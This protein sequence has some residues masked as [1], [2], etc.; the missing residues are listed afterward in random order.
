LKNSSGFLLQDFMEAT[1]PISFF[2]SF[3][4]LDTEVHTEVQPLTLENVQTHETLVISICEYGYVLISR[5]PTGVNEEWI[6][7]MSQ[8]D[9]WKYRKIS[10]DGN[11]N[12]YE[13][14]SC[15]SDV[16]GK[17]TSSLSDDEIRHYPPEIKAISRKRKATNK[18]MKKKGKKSRKKRKQS[19][20]KKTK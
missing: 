7:E 17:Y 11:D 12:R 13:Y 15:S 16:Y 1:Q 10:I 19:R 9:L 20:M 4:Q 5:Y 14:S 2:L 6:E 3:P 8:Y 18:A